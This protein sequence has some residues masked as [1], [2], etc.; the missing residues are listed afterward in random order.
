M[1]ELSNSTAQTLQPGQALTF[2][3]IPLLKT[4]CN[5]CFNKLLPTSVKLRS[6]GCNPIYSVQFH[7]NITANAAATPV[8]LSIAIANTALTGT[9]MNA[10]PAAA[11]DAVNV[12]ASK[13]IPV[14]C[15][16]CNLDRV[17][18]INSGTNPVVVNPGSLLQISRRS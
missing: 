11:G 18:I 17:S 14:G 8:Q 15:C 10:T 3:N 1:I 6:S 7:A 13:Y 12:S 16:E 9:L 5:E 2:D 4:G